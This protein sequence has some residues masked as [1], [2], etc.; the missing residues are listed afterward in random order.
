MPEPRRAAQRRGVKA[1]RSSPS[2]WS[3]PAL[4]RTGL[5]S[6]PSKAR[7]VSDLPEPDSPTSATRSAPTSKLTPST[8]NRSPRAADKRIDKSRT[9]RSARSS[10]GR[11]P[12]LA[13]AIGNEIERQA[14]YQ[15]R[16]A[17]TRGHPPLIENDLAAVGN[18]RA[19]FRSRR[20][21]PESQKAQTRR[22]E[23]DGGEIQRQADLHAGH[24]GRQHMTP[25]QAH[26]E[27]TLHLGGG[28]IV[29]A[30]HLQGFGAGKTRIG[31]PTGQRQR[32]GAVDEAGTHHPDESEC[33]H[34]RRKRHDHV[35]DAH[36]YTFDPAAAVPGHDAHRYS[37]RDGQDHDERDQ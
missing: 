5:R 1:R 28:K 16:G 27:N 9:D 22:R 7:A 21:D 13:Q 26:P 4:T 20:S 3:R 14:E 24:A 15:N 33:E 32:H 34:Q 18:H 31:R 36:E 25:E 6:K 8:S 37:D 11:V 29:A 35:G 17:G 12:R 10:T 30:A 2:N 19:P 23:D